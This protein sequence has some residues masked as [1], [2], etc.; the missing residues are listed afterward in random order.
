MTI[1]KETQANIKGTIKTLVEQKVTL[2]RKRREY[3]LHTRGKVGLEERLRFFE[4]IDHKRSTLKYDIRH[5]LLLYGF[6]RGRHYKQIERHCSDGNKPSASVILSFNN[7]L[8]L[9]EDM[10]T[11]WLDGAPSPHWRRLADEAVAA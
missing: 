7:I 8:E 2:T 5:R 9:S 3:K 11:S 6:L 1:D 4:S 10:I